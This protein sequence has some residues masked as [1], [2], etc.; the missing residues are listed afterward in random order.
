MWMAVS[1]E[2]KWPGLYLSQ[3]THVGQ[4][5]M[6]QAARPHAVSS[7]WVS[8]Q[9]Q[10]HAFKTYKCNRCCQ[11]VEH[12]VDYTAALRKLTINLWSPSKK[13]T[14]VSC[15]SSAKMLSMK[16]NVPII[17]AAPPSGPCLVQCLNGGT[18]FLNAHKQPKCRCQ[19]NYGGDRCEIDQCRDYCKNGG[20]CTPSPTGK[21]QN[22]I[23]RSV[24]Q[25]LSIRICLGRRPRMNHLPWGC[26]CRS[27][28]KVRRSCIVSL[29]VYSLR[30]CS[31]RGKYRTARGGLEW[32][33]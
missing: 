21:K 23:K 11:Y 16:Q 24:I 5:H 4:R 31:Q 20:T 2:S 12:Y 28:E 19:P 27:T 30:H 26:W 8:I 29:Y 1:S 18:C 14:L 32:P 15:P 17:S 22:L 25:L 3:R 10:A 33:E 13:C 7:L 6:R 9:T